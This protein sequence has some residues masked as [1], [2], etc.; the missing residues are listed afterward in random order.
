MFGNFLPDAFKMALM[1]LD[2]DSLEE[3]TEGVFTVQL[4]EGFVCA[5]R[6]GFL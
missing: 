2:C 4:P 5:L 1:S 3:E 6:M